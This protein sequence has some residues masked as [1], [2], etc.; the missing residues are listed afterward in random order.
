MLTR[1]IDLEDA[2][3]DLLDNCLDGV[4][5][6]QKKDPDDIDYNGYWVK[7]E[8]D[9][10]SFVIHDNCGGIPS[11]SAEYAFRMGRPADAPQEN[12]ATVG[13]YGIGMKRSIFKIGRHCNITTNHSDTDSFSV[14]IDEDWLNSDHNWKIPLQKI[15]VI[16]KRTRY[17]N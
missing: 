1:D 8:F 12:L 16:R 11:D 6:S 4:A 14:E 13:V 10:S 5:R 9:K 17:K 7:I 2:I 15:D 3:L